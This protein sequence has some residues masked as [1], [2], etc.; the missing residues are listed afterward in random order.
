[1]ELKFKNQEAVLIYLNRHFLALMY[2]YT[3]K[4]QFNARL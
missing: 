2:F 3:N 1:M 4:N